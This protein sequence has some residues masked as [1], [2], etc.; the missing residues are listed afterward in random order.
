MGVIYCHAIIQ[1]LFF[2]LLLCGNYVLS[3]YYSGVIFC[4]AI[5]WELL[6]GRLLYGILPV[7][8]ALHNP[9]V[10][11]KLIL[12]QL[13]NLNYAFSIKKRIYLKN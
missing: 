3:R 11:E 8:H 10:Y 6:L 9:N 4:L 13:F 7:K 5:M 1:E 2:V 12:V